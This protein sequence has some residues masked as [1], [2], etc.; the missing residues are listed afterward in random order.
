MW[1][2]KESLR[3]F[4]FFIYPFTANFPILKPLENVQ[5]PNQ[6]T[7]RLKSSV[8]RISNKNEIYSL[9]SRSEDTITK[10][11]F[12]KFRK[13]LHIL[14]TIFFGYTDFPNKDTTINIFLWINQSNC[15]SYR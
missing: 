12:L 1:K 10:E 8:N 6:L 9:E 11:L 14:W 5:K 2:N 3:K 7:F 4:Y 13:L 15:W